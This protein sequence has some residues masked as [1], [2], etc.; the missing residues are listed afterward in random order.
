MNEGLEHLPYE[1]C[2]KLIRKNTFDV[3]HM[4]EQEVYKKLRIEVDRT[5]PPLARFIWA[6]PVKLVWSRFS[7]EK[8]VLGIFS[9]PVK[10]LFKEK[11]DCE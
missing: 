11:A 9:I 2:F 10:W 4:I 8:S 3:I 7:I 5:F 6:I 1:E